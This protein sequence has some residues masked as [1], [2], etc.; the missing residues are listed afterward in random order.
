MKLYT[1]NA[2]YFK[3][4][5]GA[6]H[7]VVPKSM[8]QKHNPADENNMCNWAMRCMMIENGNYRVLIDTGMGDK[9][10]EK[11]FSHY[12]PHGDDSIAKNLNKH[13]FAPEDI[14]DVFLTH[15]H[16]DHCGGAIKRED[17]LL[18]PT[19]HKAIYWT[20]EKHLETA[21][22]P[23]EREKASFLKE[24]IVPLQES[25]QLQYV[26]TD[27]QQEWLT[28]ISVE[29][30]NGHTDAMMLPL[31]HYKGVK[32]LF[33]ADLLPSVAHISMP[34]IMAYD[35]RPLDTL[36]EKKKILEA[37]AAENWVLFFEHDPKVECATVQ[38]I[39]GRIRL[40]ETF[41]LSEIDKVMNLS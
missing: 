5:G 38:N 25:G 21:L 27:E 19:F 3:L 41:A 9:Q 20:N 36:A 35:M 10:D 14:T 2:G 4:D 30:A 34:W 8:W 23:N 11:F 16:F 6:M 33:C 26:I 32:I 18:V 12:H 37:A 15:L 39:E 7:G 28:D 22:D 1:I 29:V 17:G 13:G 40:K 31:I 24:N